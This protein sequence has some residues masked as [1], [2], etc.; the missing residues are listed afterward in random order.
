M[1][2]AAILLASAALPA[3]DLEVRGMTISCQTWGREWATD[4]FAT[5]LDE[6]STLGVNW[7]AIHPYARIGADGAVTWRALDPAAPPDWIARPIR[8][9]HARGLSIL[10]IPHLAH[11]G[12]PFDHRG[13]IAFEDEAAWQ[14]FFRSY[15]EWITTVAAC[16]RDADAFA[17]GSEL[18]GT[19]HRTDPWRG[20]V[21]GVRRVTAAKLVYSANWDECERV[22]FWDALDAVGVQAYFPL[23][24]VDDPDRDALRAGWK[25]VVRRLARVHARTGKPVVLTE[26]G[27]NLSLDAARLPWDHRQA[28]GADVE[29]ARALQARCYDVALET[30]GAER[31]WLR[32]AFLWKWFVGDARAN[33]LVDRP[34]VRA[35]LGAHWSPSEPSR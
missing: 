26:L 28:A 7:V 1:L 2:L 20:V 23:S 9:A 17:V 5:E 22:G 11:W 19:T 13:A 8:E 3:V 34:N 4:G 33:F 32:G 10:V 6:L 15:T 30:L 35:V 21:A 14:R 31:E 18:G 16:A 12:S 24:V 27:Y 29:R 25:D